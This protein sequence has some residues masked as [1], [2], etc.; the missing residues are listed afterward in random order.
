MFFERV[1][2]LV[3]FTPFFRHSSPSVRQTG[4][5]C[6]FTF[7]YVFW[8][9]PTLWQTAPVKA[10]YEVAERPSNRPAQEKNDLLRRALGKLIDIAK[11]KDPPAKIALGAALG[12]FIGL[13]PIMGIQ[14]AVVAVVALPFRANLKAALAGVWITN[15]VTV[16]PIYYMDYRFGLLFTSSEPVGWERFRA[17]IDEAANW[18]WSEMLESIQRILHLGADMLIPLFVGGTMLGVIFAVPTYV[19]TLRFVWRHRAKRAEKLARKRRPE[20]CEEAE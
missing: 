19:I 17:I 8:L 4:A 20:R 6:N 5:Y 14:M 2:Q 15:P 12:I 13:M 16:L 7:F 3:D 1:R 10:S 11:E 18:Q 9:G